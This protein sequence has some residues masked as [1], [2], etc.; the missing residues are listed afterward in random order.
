MGSL[1]CSGAA[2]AGT[3]SSR[4]PLAIRTSLSSVGRR[5]RATGSRHERGVAGAST[6]RGCECQPPSMLQADARIRTADP[7]ITRDA[8]V[9]VMRS[10]FAQP[11]RR[12]VSCVTSGDPFHRCVRPSCDPGSSAAKLAPWCGGGDQ[13]ENSPDPAP[14]TRR[15]LRSVLF[16]PNCE[17][18][19]K[20][21]R[22]SKTTA[23]DGRVVIIEN[24]ST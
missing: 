19:G 17:P 2:S 4:I 10:D 5:C 8:A 7:F 3:R 22:S 23:P 21:K 12:R 6:A 14:A 9:R 1:E 24:D 13:A 20:C 16:V 11:S 15:R 18:V